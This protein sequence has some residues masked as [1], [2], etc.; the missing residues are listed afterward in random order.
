MLN[1]FKGINE[2]QFKV[3]HDSISWITILIAGADGD[4]DSDELQWAEKITGIRAYAAPDKL[5]NFYIKVGHDFSDT[6]KAVMD[7]LP[8]T[9][10]KRI[11][12]LSEKLKQVNTILPSLEHDLGKELYRSYISFAKHVA[13]ASGGVMSFMSIGPEEK[14]LIDLSMINPI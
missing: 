6:L 4:I 14:A 10:K 7:S 13:K 8:D 5:Q 2:D 12:F 1:E 3:L 9:K 11:E